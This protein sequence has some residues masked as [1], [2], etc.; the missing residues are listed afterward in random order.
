MQILDHIGSGVL[1]SHTQFSNQQLAHLE[2]K[3]P[4]WY[5]YT[6]IL[7]NDFPLSSPWDHVKLAPRSPKISLSRHAF[8]LPI[9]PKPLE[10]RLGWV[11]SVLDLAAEQKCTKS[12]CIVM[13]H[14]K[15]PPF[16]LANMFL[17]LCRQ[18]SLTFSLH[19]QQWAYSLDEWEKIASP[20]KTSCPSNTAADRTEISFYRE[21]TEIGW[22][23]RYVFS[24]TMGLFVFFS[25]KKIL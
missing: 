22:K 13:P 18:P 21:K 20:Q 7:S 15:E 24:C 1:N 17:H 10:I 23:D 25:K 5:S 6:V 16:W 9:E 12:V 2:W 4:P 11:F 19:F 8:L 14:E 3:R